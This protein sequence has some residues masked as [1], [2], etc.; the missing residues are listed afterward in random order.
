VAALLL[1]GS[2]SAAGPGGWSHL[3]EPSVNDKVSA[4]NTDRP[5]TL[6]A[7][8]SFT[9]AGGVTGTARIASWD[10]STW[11]AVSSP[12]S[13]ISNGIV[14]AIAYDTTTGHVFAGGTFT[15][16]GGDPNAD[17]LAVWNGTSWAPFCTGASPPIT[18]TVS[19][20][21][22]IGRTLYIAGSFADGAGIASADRLVACN[23]DTGASSSTVIDVAHAF[24]GTVYALAADSNGVLY[25]GGG[26]TDLGGD[27][28]ADNIAYMDGS[29][30]HAMGSGAGAC[31]CAVNTFVRSLA[32]IGTDVYAGTDARDVAGIAQA[33]NVARWNGSSWSA[34]GANTAG[35]DG[36]FP[37]TAVIYGLAASTNP[38][39]GSGQT[40]V[41]T[42]SFQNAGG[43]ATADDIAIF[44]GTNWHA[45]GSDGAGNGPWSGNGLAVAIPHDALPDGSL[46][47]YAGGNFTSAGGDG[48]AGYIASYA[49][50]HKLTVKPAGSG[51]GTVEGSGIDCPPACVASYPTG[52]TVTLHQTTPPGAS[53][54][55]FT[56]GCSST[57]D[58]VA[59]IDADK[60][61]QAIWSLPPVCVSQSVTAVS[62]AAT[63]IQLTCSNPG[64]RLFYGIYAYSGPKHGTM[65]PL[66]IN[67]APPES[68]TMTYTPAAGYV[69]P[70]SFIYF[71]LL[72]V[73]GILPAFSNDAMTT[74]AVVPA[75]FSSS[76]LLVAVV[77]GTLQP[78]GAGV[79][80]LR[81]R[82]NNTF[83]VQE[84]S[85]TVTSLN[86]VAAAKRHKLV[87]LHSSKAVTL[88][89]GKTV[90]LKRRL[91][92]KARALLKRL[93]RVPVRIA[94]VLKAPDKT[95]RTLSAKGKLVRHG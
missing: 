83:A 55:G 11:S 85:V 2:A 36:W 23:V 48:N 6:Y 49:L 84:L 4:L 63:P 1:P 18:A 95:R 12:G 44:D 37:A 80:S 5:G 61:V 30:W 24:S 47:L 28:A 46:P 38:L 26:F 27:P 58:C 39:A 45:A 68:G 77:Q 20:L 10:G 42:G 74:I 59:V 40:V 34:L 13:Q 3:G 82:N 64:G 29:G 79:L 75:G 51:I 69:G 72:D 78:T 89:A 16:A 32:A 67:G 50:S 57:G 81:L 60:T 71:A 31:G 35:D 70:D 93:R 73:G 62:G 19:A 87:L 88:P 15:N 8:G 86:A 41:A 56:N 43:D 25:A 66:D 14:N 91:S 94:V 90:T 92:A 65:A 33:D 22:I 21:Q 76:G 52:S 53:F 7:G 17:Y 54:L 9:A